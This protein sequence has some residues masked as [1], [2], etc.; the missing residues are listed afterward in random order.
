MKTIDFAAPDSISSLQDESLRELL[1]YLE[2]HSPF[3]KEHFRKHSIDISKI[4]TTKDL[5]KIPVVSKDELQQHNMDFL[6]VDPGAVIEYCTT[7]GTMGTPVTIA[8]T[9][10]DLQR[11]AKNELKSFQS[12]A[13]TNQDI[14]LLMLSLDRQF[15]AGIAYYLGAREL[16]AG[17]I[18]GGPGNFSMQLE[19]INRLKPTVLVAV[20]SFLVGLVAYAGENHIDLNATSVRKII[21]IGENIRNDDLTPNPLHERICRNWKVHLFSTYASTE[22]QTAFTE[23]SYGR[24]GHHHPE[25]L[26]FEVID[27][28]GNQLPPGEYGELVITTLGVEGMPLLRYN[29]GDICTWYNESCPCGRNSARISPIA[30]RKQQMIK[31]KGTTIYPQAIFNILNSMEG[32]QDYV[33][34]LLNNDLGNDD[35]KIKIAL[36]PGTSLTDARI[37]QG[38]QSALRV[39]PDLTFLSI[40]EI[41]K[42]QVV[43]GKR[44]IYKLIDLRKSRV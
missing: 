40:S 2:Q 19:L 7:S 26:I 20:P 1:Q 12:A 35:I 6:C 38:L 44:K 18:R 4:N 28:N 11:L 43:E 32:I 14:I 33:I 36:R 13:L 22:Q 8:L 17:I 5:V 3:Y 10:K 21:C 39:V 34:D 37:R 31:Y 30:G 29:T 15:M 9:E 25:L 16:G 41:Q 24:G 27:E 23:C 42:M